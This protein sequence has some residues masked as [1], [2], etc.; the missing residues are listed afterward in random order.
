MKILITGGTGI[1]GGA[2][3]KAASGKGADVHII[4][5]QAPT[6]KWKEINAVHI[7]GDWFDDDFAKSVVSQGF[8]VIIDTLIFDE[9]HM[10][11]SADIVNGHCKQFIF[12]STDSVYPH[13]GDNVT[14]DSDNTGNV[15]WTYGLN[16]FKAEQYLK[17]HSS[18]YGFEW[19]VVR[20]TITFGETRIPVGF[21]ARRNTYNLIDRLIKGKPVLR[22]DDPDSRHALCHDIVFGNAVSG[23]L[24]NERSYGQCYHISDD[25]AYTYGEIF[26]VIENILEVKGKYV[27]LSPETL[28]RYTPFYE[29][30]IY[31]K[32]P[33]FTLDNKKIRSV[34]PDVNFGCDMSQAL[35]ATIRHLE[36][37]KDI[38]VQDPEYDLLTDL[39]LYK[40]AGSSDEEVRA[41][42]N[43]FTDEYVR[44]LKCFDR[45]YVSGLIKQKIK[46]MLGPAYRT[47]KKSLRRKQ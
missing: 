13:P 9:K 4:H 12:I 44:R 17:E 41:Y 18:G 34:C 6:G 39:I 36:E 31:D 46:D 42:V 26:S 37:Q 5:R 14:E 25:K 22:F 16:K 28:R 2:V 47:I 32:D 8:D 19:T 11:R 7:T 43:G 30:M 1:I 27:H 35:S 29:D 40:N 15:K 33:E 21:Q 10:K 24:L 45:D 3:A 23:L 20:P 38:S